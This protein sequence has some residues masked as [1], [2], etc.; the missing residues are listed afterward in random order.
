MEPEKEIDKKE[1]INYEP[2]NEIIIDNHKLTYKQKLSKDNY[3]YRCKQR[4][5]Y[6]L[7]ITISREDLDKLLK[8]DTKTKIKYKISSGQKTHTCNQDNNE[9]ISENASLFKSSYLTLPELS[10]KLMF[11]N[12]EKAFSC[13]KANLEKNKILLSDNQ[14]KYLLQILREI[15]S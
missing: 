9:E 11:L 7:T 15:N 4:K 1:K 3:S 8:K 5:H 14:I 6:S 12:L 10:I 2:P 13:H